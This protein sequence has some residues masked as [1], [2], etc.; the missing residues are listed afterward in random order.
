MIAVYVVIAVVVVA[1]AVL[2]VSVRIIEQYERVVLLELGKVKDTAR[3]PGVMFII[4]LVDRVHRVSLRTITMPVQSQGIITKDNV[5]DWVFSG[6]D[7]CRSQRSA[8]GDTELTADGAGTRT[9]VIEAR[10]PRDRPAT[11]VG[12]ATGATGLTRS[13]L[14]VASSF[15][16]ASY[17]PRSTLDP[18]DGFGAAR[19]HVAIQASGSSML[20]LLVM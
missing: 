18:P 3:G 7:R 9:L 19:R 14:Q 5:R 2:A 16:S 11:R 13:A 4:P 17:S 1:L 8:S 12:L 20:T 6:D 15:V 10:G